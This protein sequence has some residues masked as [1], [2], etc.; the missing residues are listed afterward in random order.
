M[1]KIRCFFSAAGG[2]T[3]S[4]AAVGGD[5]FLL[6]YKRCL[7]NGAFDGHTFGKR[8]TGTLTEGQYRML[9]QGWRLRPGA[10]ARSQAAAGSPVV[11][12]GYENKSVKAIR[13]PQASRLWTYPHAYGHSHWRGYTNRYMC[14]C[15]T[16]S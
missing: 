15:V 8:S 4:S 13:K 14:G 11:C 5:G 2:A 1:I 9:M 16:P 6:L 12:A 10:I 7:D 3:G